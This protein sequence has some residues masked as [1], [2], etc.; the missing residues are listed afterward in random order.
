MEMMEE[1]NHY[2]S[3]FERLEKQQAAPALQRLRKAAIG[4]SPSWAFR[5][6]ATRNGASPPLKL[7]FRRRSVLAPTPTTAP[8]RRRAD[9]CPK[10]F[11]SPGW[12]RRWTNI[13]AGRAAPGALRR[14]QAQRLRRPQHRLPP[15]RCC[16]STSRPARRSRSRSTSATSS[17]ASDDAGAYAW[18]RRCLVVL[19]PNSQATV[20]EIVCRAAAGLLHQRR[21]RGRG[22]RQR[23]T[24]PLQGPGGRR[25]G[26]PHGPDQV[27]LGRAASFSSHAFSLGGRLVAQRDQRRLRR[28][29]RGMHAQRPVPR[30]RPAVHS[31][32]TRSS[33]TPTRTA[34][35]T[36]CT[37]AS[38]TARPA[39][40][41]TARSTSARTPRRPT[42]SRPTRRCC[43]P[44]TPR[45]TP[46]RSWRSTPTT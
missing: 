32:T 23:G 45:S 18:H 19:G 43:C 26:V 1:T 39:A 3:D 7:S 13:R 21:H 9:R 33:T 29:G 31:T 40:S 5:G 6:R 41:S 14:L 28:R 20:V 30:R 25:R 4:A 37:R 34:P 35:A 44:T 2:L 12:P 15:R 27:Q 17:L 10:A 38:S 11:S 46:S 36:S 8:P 16:S 24:R 22:R 42:P